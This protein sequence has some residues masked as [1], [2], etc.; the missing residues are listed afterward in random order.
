MALY[1]QTANGETQTETKT[2]G[3]AIAVDTS[4]THAVRMSSGTSASTAPGVAEHSE[5]DNAEVWSG[6][7]SGN[8][9][10]WR[11]ALSGLLGYL[12]SSKSSAKAKSRDSPARGA[13]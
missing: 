8:K 1:L 4:P 6:T 5:G 7:R 12:S 10:P 9:I 13:D 3:G 11:R 2:D